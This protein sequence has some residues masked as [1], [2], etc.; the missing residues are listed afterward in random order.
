MTYS[1]PRL[2]P[3]P[4]LDCVVNFYPCDIMINPNDY[5]VKNRVLRYYA[6]PVIKAFLLITSI[7]D[8][9]VT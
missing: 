4:L 7:K 5:T 1:S 6:I 8:V 2:L 3:P 9:G